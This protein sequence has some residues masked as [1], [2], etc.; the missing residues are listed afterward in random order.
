MSVTEVRVA[1]VVTQALLRMVPNPQAAAQVQYKPYGGG[2]STAAAIPK[3]F[4]LRCTA[5]ATESAPGRR[6]TTSTCFLGQEERQE[7]TDLL[8]TSSGK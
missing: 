1:D 4:A 5:R 7:D 3:P 6:L 2:E 8:S